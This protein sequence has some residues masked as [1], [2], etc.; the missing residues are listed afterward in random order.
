MRRLAVYIFLVFGVIARQNAWADPAHEMSSVDSTSRTASR[1]GFS[2]EKLELPNAADL[3]PKE[4]CN[5]AGMVM[6]FCNAL[7]LKHNCEDLMSLRPGAFQMLKEE[8]MSEL[9][10]KIPGTLKAIKE[11]VSKIV[12]AKRGG[13]IKEFKKQFELVERKKE[14]I[15]AGCDAVGE[16]ATS[17]N[18]H[19]ASTPTIENVDFENPCLAI[20]QKSDS[21]TNACFRTGSNAC[22]ALTGSVEL[23]NLIP[24]DIYEA[25][26]AS[27]IPLDLPEYLKNMIDGSIDVF[28][29]Q[30]AD[31]LNNFVSRK[32]VAKAGPV[33]AIALA[34][35]TAASKQIYMASKSGDNDWAHCLGSDNAGACFH[36]LFMGGIPKSGPLARAK[37]V[38]G[39]KQIECCYCKKTLFSV[40][41][42]AFGRET[43]IRTDDDLTPTEVGP[44]ADTFCHQQENHA[45]EQYL[46]SHLGQK[47]F[48]RKHN[49]QKATVSGESCLLTADT[50]ITPIEVVKEELATISTEPATSMSGVKKGPKPLGRLFA[51]GMRNSDPKPTLDRFEERYTLPPALAPKRYDWKEERRLQA[52]RGAAV[53]PV[54]NVTPAPRQWAPT[55]FAKPENNPAAVA[56]PVVAMAAPMDPAAYGLDR[57]SPLPAAA[58][59]HLRS[60]IRNARP[61]HRASP[62]P[63][64][65]GDAGFGDGTRNAGRSGRCCFG[66]RS[67]PTTDCGTRG[68][69]N[70]DSDSAKSRRR[71]GEH[72]DGRRSSGTDFISRIRFTHPRPA[73]APRSG[74]YADAAT[75]GTDEASAIARVPY[76][77]LRGADP[78]WE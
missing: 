37:T 50:R 68:S 19:G 1:S 59:D 33:G 47:V 4:A 18:D 16:L 46:S 54:A 77:S 75:G 27:N 70:S 41:A 21:R 49:C 34:T 55:I 28:K 69:G 76:P 23:E 35:M 74:R 64:Q 5:L 66:A 60:V 38:D 67:R 51:A 29:K 22:K 78:D 31:K 12:G 32:I 61:G 9:R 2:F 20:F 39:K 10:R 24:P 6:P 58:V 43:K 56:V 52:S 30:G 48:F 7:E 44:L 57:S 17:G 11:C 3:T 63:E 26:I 73:S 40:P 15:R 71:L 42:F 45:Q 53:I 36:D 72:R 13:L 25:S 62:A 14:L 8:E 65:C